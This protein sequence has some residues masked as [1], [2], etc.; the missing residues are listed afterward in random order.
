MT[1]IHFNAGARGAQAAVRAAERSLGLSEGRLSSGLRIA[2]A[3]DN[4][5]YW[6]ISRSMRS[7]IASFAMIADGLNHSLAVLD[8]AL[9][10]A[11]PVLKG[12]D[13][14]KEIFVAGRQATPEEALVYDREIRSI[15]DGLETIV[16][17]ASFAGENL[18]Y[19]TNSGPH[20][21]SFLTGIGRSSD[22]SLAIQRM[23]LNLDQT[24]LID[25]D[26]TWGLLSTTYWDRY[27]FTTGRRLFSKYG[28]TAWLLGFYNS[29][30]GSMFNNGGRMANVD[31]IEQIA[32][33]V[34][35]GFATLGAFR[36]RLQ[37]QRDLVQQ[38][39]ITQV[40]GLGRLVDANLSEE[41]VRLRAEDIRR[42]LALQALQIA[43]GLPG[44]RALALLS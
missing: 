32:V 43:N 20:S 26:K 7:D 13:R 3:R 2:S 1:G 4:P 40:R 27:N 31:L 21:K 42:Q 17:S 35:S 28:G 34:R 41:S 19:R 24:V 18:L 11:V 6:S 29:Q 14:I 25:E 38:L 16:K 44:R 37:T 23:T 33:A 8:T 5:S 36:A 9:A 30:N 15:A 12:V 39:G 22:G 10:A